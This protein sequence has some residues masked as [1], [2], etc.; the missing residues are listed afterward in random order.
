M[1]GSLPW[2]PPHRLYCACHHHRRPSCDSALFCF[3]LSHSGEKMIK[4]NPPSRCIFFFWRLFHFNRLDHDGCDRAVTWSGRCVCNRID[5][6]LTGDHF[7]KNRVGGWKRVVLMH[8]EELTAVRIRSGIRHCKYTTL[9]ALLIERAL[10]IYL[11]GKLIAWS[12]LTPRLRL[13]VI[14]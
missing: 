5:N 2:S 9:V 6:I 12:T 8:N 13:A 10:R 4:K 3:P 11:I 14:F 7:T 1:D